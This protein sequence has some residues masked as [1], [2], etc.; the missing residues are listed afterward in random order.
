MIDEL[1]M[2]VRRPGHIEQTARLMKET[3]A[4]GVVVEYE[5]IKYVRRVSRSIPYLVYAQRRVRNYAEA[6]RED[7]KGKAG[8]TEIVKAGASHVIFDSEYVRR[9]NIEW[10]ADMIIKELEAATRS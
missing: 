2:R 9:T 7:E 6:D 4:D 8:I 3:G 1:R 5:D 10:A